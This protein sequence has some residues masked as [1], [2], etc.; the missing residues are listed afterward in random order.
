M[1]VLV[2]N[3]VVLVAFSPSHPQNGVAL[4]SLSV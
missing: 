1:V 2:A 4:F 3:M